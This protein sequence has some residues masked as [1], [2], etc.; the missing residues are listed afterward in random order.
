MGNQHAE[1]QNDTSI[2]NMFAKTKTT[3]RRQYH[4]FVEKG[5]D[6]GRR[7]EL[8]GGGL[9]RSVGGWKMAKT[10]LKGQDRVKGDER[11]LGDSDF[12][13]SVLERCNE[14]YTRRQRLV[15]QGVDLK[16]LSHGVAD[17]FD[18]SCDQLFTPGRYPAVVQARSVLCFL[19]VRE[20]GLTA[21]ELARQMG[22]THPAISISIKRGE[23][24][25]REEKLNIDD[26]I[27]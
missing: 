11:I 27:I 25:V 3:A 17:Y 1:W 16:S 5:I 4:Q 10:L 13:Q 19:A 9:I 2:L 26:F 15:A 8:V 18:L 7:P 14:T 20:L 6:A 24:N 23:R 12:V 21:T 22:L